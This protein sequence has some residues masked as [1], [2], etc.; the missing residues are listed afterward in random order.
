M[1][2]LCLCL[3][4]LF[5]CTSYQ[6]FTCMA[7]GSFLPFEFADAAINACSMM[8]LTCWCMP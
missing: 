1:R 8:T 5:P 3:S 6:I 2:S 4:A 7:A